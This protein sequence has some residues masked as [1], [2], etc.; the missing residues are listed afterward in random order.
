MSVLF[1]QVSQIVLARPPL[2]HSL[3]PAQPW[4]HKAPMQKDHPVTTQQN[5]SESSR[6]LRF[7][8]LTF[9]FASCLPTATDNITSQ[10]FLTLMAHPAINQ[11]KRFTTQSEN[12]GPDDIA[13]WEPGIF[14]LQAYRSSLLDVL[15]QVSSH[16]LPHLVPSDQT[17]EQVTIT[18]YTQ[19]GRHHYPVTTNLSS[20]AIKLAAEDIETMVSQHEKL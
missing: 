17:L 10:L 19:L 15:T 16:L 12:L 7:L 11:I 6:P 9:D 3:L 18:I 5:T 14:T 20:D 4:Y 8:W 13:Q 2:L 1:L